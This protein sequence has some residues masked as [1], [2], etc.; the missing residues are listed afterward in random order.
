MYMVIYLSVTVTGVISP[1]KSCL[2]IT[3]FIQFSIKLNLRLKKVFLDNLNNSSKLILSY[4]RQKDMIGVHI[5]QKP[6]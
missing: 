1:D 6:M 3:I 2:V 4:V 5:Y